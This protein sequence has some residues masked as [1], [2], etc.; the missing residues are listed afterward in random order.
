MVYLVYSSNL[1]FDNVYEDESEA[2]M[3][4]ISKN[5]ESEERWEVIDLT[6]YKKEPSK[7][8]YSEED[9]EMDESYY[10][11]RINEL[12][13]IIDFERNKYKVLETFTRSFIRMLLI[14]IVVLALIDLV[15]C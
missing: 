10:I 2:H 9:S 11:D 6:Y 4:C 14:L 7:F 3:M 13:T 12:N 1:K 8:H 15:L 5:I